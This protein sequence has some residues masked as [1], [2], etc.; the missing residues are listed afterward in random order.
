MISTSGNRVRATSSRHKNI[1]LMEKLLGCN[2]IVLMFMGWITQ[3]MVTECYKRFRICSLNTN[4]P[5][6]EMDNLILTKIIQNNA[7]SYKN[8]IDFLK[9]VPPYETL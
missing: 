2:N 1:I 3:M 7:L 6:D 9:E 4:Y 5:L 8:L